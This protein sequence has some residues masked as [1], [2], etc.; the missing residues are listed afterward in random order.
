MMFHKNFLVDGHPLSD[1]QQSKV[2][3]SE[4]RPDFFGSVTFDLRPLTAPDT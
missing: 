3:R 2:F 4:D 1:D